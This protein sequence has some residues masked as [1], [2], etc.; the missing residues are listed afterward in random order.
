[1]CAMLPPGKALAG[2]RELVRGKPVSAK[3]GTGEAVIHVSMGFD[4][5]LKIFVFSFT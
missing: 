4:D 5:A 2:V 3:V 1:M